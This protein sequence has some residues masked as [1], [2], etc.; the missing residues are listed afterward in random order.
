MSTNRLIG[1]RE[2][3]SNVV[4]AKLYSLNRLSLRV[5]HFSNETNFILSYSS[6]HITAITYNQLFIREID[7]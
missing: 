7:Q 1:Y 6:C 3:P 4:Y 2:L 5:F